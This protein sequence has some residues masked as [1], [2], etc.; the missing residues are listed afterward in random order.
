MN[1]PEHPQIARVLATG[2]PEPVS[3]PMN[4]VECGAEFNHFES[5]F[6]Y[7]GDA[8]CENCCRDRI[9]EDFNMEDIAKAL[10]IIVQSLEEYTANRKENDYA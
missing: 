3:K 5:V 4:C 10:Q 8:I 1:I 6:L 2:Y 9:M 7:D